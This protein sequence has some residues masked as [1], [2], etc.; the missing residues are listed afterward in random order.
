LC[1]PYFK[2]VNLKIS[3][4]LLLKIFMHFPKS[5]KFIVDKLRNILQ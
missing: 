5:T 3:D 1:S 2:K 4:K